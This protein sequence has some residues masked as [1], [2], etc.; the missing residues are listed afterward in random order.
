MMYVLSENLIK[1]ILTESCARICSKN[2]QI[3][4]IHVF[5]LR[6]YQVALRI[7]VSIFFVV[8][9]IGFLLKTFS[10]SCL[11]LYLKGG[12]LT[13]LWNEKKK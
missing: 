10:R 11:N 3:W 8:H 9:D 4:M 7:C 2:G 6:L 12:Y 13:I 1:L 5:L